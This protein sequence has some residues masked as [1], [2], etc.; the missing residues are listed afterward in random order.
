MKKTCTRCKEEKLTDDF[1]KWNRSSDG[2]QS[3]CKKCCCEANRASRN[4][5]NGL[6]SKIYL[7]QKERSKLKGFEP[8]SYTK[9]ELKSWMIS[10]KNFN[11]IHSA[12]IESGH[13][14]D[15]V[16]SC[17]RIN[18]YEGYTLENI[19]LTS[20]LENRE[21]SSRDRVSGVNNKVSKAVIKIDSESD[22]EIERFHSIKEAARSIGNEKLASSISECCKG[23]RK[24]TKGFKWKF[25]YT[26]A[27]A[28]RLQE[29]RQ[30]RHH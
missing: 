6:I 15:L 10:Q 4:T 28:N 11:D 12:W 22:E 23:K 2:L 20:W 21:R 13:K 8:P 5:L 1:Y 24:T 19:R 29:A 25:P 9:E 7:A 16:P 26:E 3:F 27:K 18:D 30:L 14:K 17:D